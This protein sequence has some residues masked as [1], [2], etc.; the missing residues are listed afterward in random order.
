MWPWKHVRPGEVARVQ[1]GAGTAYDDRECVVLDAT[2]DDLLVIEFVGQDELEL[3][4]PDAVRGTGERS[5]GPLAPYWS[6][7]MA[8][9]AQGR[10]QDT[11][12]GRMVLDTWQDFLWRPRPDS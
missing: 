2:D 4:P 7:R 3:L 9:D 11:G 8:V 12:D 1:P 6:P 10:E 5:P